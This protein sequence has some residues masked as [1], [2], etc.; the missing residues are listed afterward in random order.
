MC[1]SSGA[2]TRASCDS[3]L[4]GEIAADERKAAYKGGRSAGFILSRISRIRNN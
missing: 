4:R 2:R 3:A 1:V